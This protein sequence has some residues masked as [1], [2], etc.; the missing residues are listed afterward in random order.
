MKNNFQL[1]FIDTVLVI[2]DMYGCVLNVS[3]KVSNSFF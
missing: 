2:R 3:K 1:D